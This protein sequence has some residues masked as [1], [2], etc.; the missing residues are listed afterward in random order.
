VV[1]EAE[2]KK[3]DSAANV[4]KIWRWARDKKNTRR[5]LFVQGFSKLYWQ[6]KV[7]VRES[8][9]FV[10]ERMAEAGLHI[11]YEPQQIRYRNKI[12]RWVCFR[13]RTGGKVGA[14]RLALAAEG[15]AKEVAGLVRQF[16]LTDN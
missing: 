1:I 4:I 2:L 16:K 6:T 12:G 11:D 13:P 7:R 8:A 9:E 5:I 3:D 14:G 10:G 15:F